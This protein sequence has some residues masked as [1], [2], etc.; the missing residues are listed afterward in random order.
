MWDE[1]P[2]GDWSWNYHERLYLFRGGA[3]WPRTRIQGWGPLPLW[4]GRPDDTLF[5]RLGSRRTCLIYKR[6]LKGG[7]SGE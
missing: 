1:Y 6:E 4:V 5:V 7:S 3:R 2:L